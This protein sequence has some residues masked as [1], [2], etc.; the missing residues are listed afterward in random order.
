MTHWTAGAQ[1]QADNGQVPRL[2]RTARIVALRSATVDGPRDGRGQT[3]RRSDSCKTDDGE[4]GDR[5]TAAAAVHKERVVRESAC[6][7]Q[8]I[9]RTG[10][11]LGV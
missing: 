7:M 5:V 10:L 3:L 1:Q 4:G 9:Q 2:R 8:P 6:S 11:A